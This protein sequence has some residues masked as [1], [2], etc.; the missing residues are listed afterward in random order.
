MY[1]CT[2]TS[3]VFHFQVCEKLV[4]QH[5][6]CFWLDGVNSLFTEKLA[7]AKKNLSEDVVVRPSTEN[8]L[9]KVGECN[10]LASEHPSSSPKRLCRDCGS[11]DDRLI[12][13]QGAA[14]CYNPSPRLDC[15]LSDQEVPTIHDPPSTKVSDSST[16][17]SP[18]TPCHIQTR[19]GFNR[20]KWNPDFSCFYCHTK[21]RDPTPSD[22]TLYLH[23]YKYK[24]SCRL[25]PR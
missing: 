22:L 21:F 19:I 5:N 3:Q 4:Q 7:N 25:N 13:G 6:A 18:V 2:F 11:D 12:F 15:S 9:G 16:S 14:V 17:L 24:V 10:T 8:A 23:A 20:E 1:V